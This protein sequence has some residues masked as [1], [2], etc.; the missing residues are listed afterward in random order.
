ML[1]S[2]KAK[3]GVTQW[4]QFDWRELTD[5]GEANGIGTNFWA[6]DSLGRTED[7]I[8]GTGIGPGWDVRLDC[9]LSDHLG[10]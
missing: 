9:L 8:N 4:K 7:N 3:K 6:E 10:K 1:G 2:V 5:E